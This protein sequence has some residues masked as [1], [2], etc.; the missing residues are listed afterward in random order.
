MRRFAPL[1]LLAGALLAGS[2]F[3]KSLPEERE[4]ELR[5]EDAASVVHLDVTWTDPSSGDGATDATP[6]H[7]SSWNFAEGTAPRSVLTRVRL[8]DGLYNLEIAVDRTRGRDTTRRAVTLGDSTRI[9]FPV[10]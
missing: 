4:I 10:R 2:T 5:L 9:T 3:L 6:I 7:G 8:P 1:I